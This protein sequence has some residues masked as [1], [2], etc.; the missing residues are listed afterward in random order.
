[1]ASN[2]HGWNG[3]KLVVFEGLD[4]IGKSTQ[5]RRVRSALVRRGWR[6]K[7]FTFPNGVLP[8]GVLLRQH[9]RGDATLVPEAA[10][11][12]RTV[13]RKRTCKEM[14]RYLSRGNVVV[15]CDRYMLPRA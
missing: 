9:E 11:L 2:I 8:S 1:M 12:L 4:R 14:K 5:I 3:G 13:N 15:L 7:T 6:V 10:Y